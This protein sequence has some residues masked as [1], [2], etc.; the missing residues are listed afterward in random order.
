[1]GIR[2]KEIRRGKAIPSNENKKN[3]KI[4]GKI[5]MKKLKKEKKNFNI[6]DK[7]IRHRS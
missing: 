3:E 1:L 2:H 5:K 4:K 7:L 6:I